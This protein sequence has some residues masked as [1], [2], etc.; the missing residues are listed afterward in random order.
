M[1]N[2]QPVRSRWRCVGGMRCVWSRRD[3][4][5][6]QTRCGCHM[7][8]LRPQPFRISEVLRRALQRKN[9]PRDLLELVRNIRYCGKRLRNFKSLYARWLSVHTANDQCKVLGVQ[10]RGQQRAQLHVQDQQS[11][12][13]VI[14]TRA[15]NHSRTVQHANEVMWNDLQTLHYLLHG[16]VFFVPEGFIFLKKIRFSFLRTLFHLN[17]FD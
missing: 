7:S 8:H 10:G 1:T 12:Q 4:A 11:V 9:V 13:V 16:P 14:Q 17:C 15:C 5:K 6:Y 3:L 2:S